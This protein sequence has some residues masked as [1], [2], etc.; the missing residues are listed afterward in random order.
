ESSEDEAGDVSEVDKDALGPL[1]DRVRPVS[2]H[3]F[4]KSGRFE[5]SPSL[6]VSFKDAFFTKYLLG[7]TLTYHPIETI[8]I[9]FR[10]GYTLP[11]DGGHTPISGAAQICTTLVTSKT[12]SCSA[13]SYDQVN[14]VAPG[15]IGLIAGVDLQ[16]APLYGKIALLAQYF[17]HFDLYGI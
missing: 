11:L 17:P 2:G 7:A 5:M 16:W 8:G 9:S 4:L 6:T 13:P 10:A 15:Q 14:G 1:R 3:V 12:P